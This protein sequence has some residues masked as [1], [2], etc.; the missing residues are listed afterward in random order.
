M[1]ISNGF[2]RYQIKDKFI[3]TYRLKPIQSNPYRLIPAIHTNNIKPKFHF[4]HESI[5][6]QCFN[7]FPLHLCFPRW[8]RQEFGPFNSCIRCQSHLSCT[9][10]DF[11]G[12]VGGFSLLPYLFGLTV[13]GYLL[14]ESHLKVF[15]SWWR[16]NG[17][18]STL[19]KWCNTKKEAG[20]IC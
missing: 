19:R 15:N 20:E 4:Q 12:Q 1:F 5:F 11:E 3:S 17:I 9:N 10:L 2:N 6:N 7:H 16:K 8:L 14:T 13:N 18:S